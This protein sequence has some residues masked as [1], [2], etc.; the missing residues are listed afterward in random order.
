VRDYTTDSIES[1]YRADIEKL[2]T[3][4]VIIPLDRTDIGCYIGGFDDM[5]RKDTDELCREVINLLEFE[6]LVMNNITEDTKA[7]RFMT[8]VK[9]CTQKICRI[10]DLTFIDKERL[11]LSGEASA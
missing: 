2:G 9:N 7:N 6:I 3:Y 8:L 11:F 5:N 4:S 10:N 1:K